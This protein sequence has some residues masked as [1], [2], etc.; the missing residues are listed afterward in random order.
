MTIRLL[1]ILFFLTTSVFGQNSSDKKRVDKY[2]VDID[3]KVKSN[4]LVLKNYPDRSMFGGVLTGYYLNSKLVL[5]KTDLAVAF[6]HSQRSYYVL[7]DSLIFVSE[8]TTRIKEPDNFDEYIKEHTDKNNNTDLSK[9]PLEVDDDNIYYLN[10]GNITNCQLKSFNKKIA[11]ME[12]V[13]AE[14]NKMI[15]QFYKAHLDELK[16]VQ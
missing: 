5:I 3:K 9:L 10:D 16:T 1:I 8:R 15:L 11:V 14:K 7:N 12:D 13:G 6:S 4:K 2:K